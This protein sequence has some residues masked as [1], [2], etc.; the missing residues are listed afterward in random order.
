M[1]HH[2]LNSLPPKKSPLRSFSMGM[3]SLLSAFVLLAVVPYVSSSWFN[4]KD[5]QAEAIW[6]I[7]EATGCA[8]GYTAWPNSVAKN[9]DNPWNLSMFDIG[10]DG[11]VSY[12]NVNG[13]YAPT[14]RE[15]M[16]DINGDALPDYVFSY[17]DWGVGNVVYLNG[18]RVSPFPSYS[19]DCVYLNTGNG[20]QK[21]YQCVYANGRYYGDCSV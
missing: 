21:G 4:S 7:D 9:D 13:L 19:V 10:P 8:A 16:M 6:H 12:M 18:F 5:N 14:N 3:M 2:P 11:Y 15:S 17:K 20:W 1:S